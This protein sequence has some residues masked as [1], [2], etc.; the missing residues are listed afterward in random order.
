MRTACHFSSSVR[1]PDD[2]E[3]VGRSSERS[4][5]VAAVEAA[6]GIN[7]DISLYG[8]FAA[9]VSEGTPSGR[10]WEERESS[11][12]KNAPRVVRSACSLG[13][14]AKDS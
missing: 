4:G 8:C 3:G 11:G 13:S 9:R 14:A 6:L 2:G 10:V 7:I 1:K 12:A 5:V